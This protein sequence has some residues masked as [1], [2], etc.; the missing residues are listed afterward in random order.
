[1]RLK[2]KGVMLLL[3]A[4][5]G[6]GY[7]AAILLL[8]HWVSTGQIGLGA[9][10]VPVGLVMIMALGWIMVDRKKYTPASMR[11]QIPNHT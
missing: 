3:N 4:L 10:L 7:V 2:H 9:F 6:G 5:F 11:N 1:M 8:I